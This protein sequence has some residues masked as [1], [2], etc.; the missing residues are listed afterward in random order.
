MLM[1]HTTLNTGK[2]NNSYKE[3]IFF[4]STTNAKHLAYLNF[5]IERKFG[6]TVTMDKHINLSNYSFSDTD[7]LVL[8]H[9][10]DF[11]IPPKMIDRIKV[12][13]EFEL[14]LPFSQ[15]VKHVLT[16]AENVSHLKVHLNELAYDYKFIY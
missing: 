2:S 7:K 10:L 13:S 9:G 8:S 16:S 5:L 11:C 12:F 15:L 4:S 1:L 14:L 3:D 6:V